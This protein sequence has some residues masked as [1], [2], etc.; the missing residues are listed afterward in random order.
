[1]KNVKSKLKFINFLNKVEREMG[2]CIR[3][4][5]KS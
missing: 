1:M 3:N 5:Q 2:K 4:N